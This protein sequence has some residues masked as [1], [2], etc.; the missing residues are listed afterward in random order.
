MRI[1][2]KSR[3]K[4]HV[5]LINTIISIIT[6]ILTYY[7]VGTEELDSWQE[8]G[9]LILHAIKNPYILLTTIA[10][11]WNNLID[12]TTKGVSDCNIKIN[13]IRKDS[14]E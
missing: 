4:N 14:Y 7:G 3:F 8:I 11:I 9:Q 1:D 10:L 12:P 5:F 6:P 13:T 2:L